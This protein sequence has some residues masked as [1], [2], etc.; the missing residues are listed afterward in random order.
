MSTLLRSGNAV[1]KLVVGFH[2]TGV[3]APAAA[4]VTKIKPL[5]D[6]VSKFATVDT[7]QKSMKLVTSQPRAAKGINEMSFIGELNLEPLK[8]PLGFIRCVQLPFIIIAL[9]SKNGWG[10]ELLYNCGLSKISFRVDS[11]N[12]GDLLVPMCINGTASGE[13][14]KLWKDSFGGSSWFFGLVGVLSLFFVLGMLYI[15]VFSWGNYESNEKV[16]IVDFAVTTGLA[17]FWFIAS[18]SWWSSTNG[19]AALTTNEYINKALVGGNFCENKP[20]ESPSQ[21]RNASLSISVLAGWA[22]V[23]LFAA[24]VWFAWK[25]TVWFRNRQTLQSVGNAQPTTHIQFP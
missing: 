1:A 17:C 9:F 7:L 11:F 8:V 15:Y 25:E 6:T 2:A 19:I 10:F 20:C 18:W 13:S 23:L 22:C 21:G 12:L 4:G 5:T 14:A 16:P 24:N 3:G